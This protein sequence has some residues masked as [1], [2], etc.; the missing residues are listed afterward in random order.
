MVYIYSSILIIYSDIDEL[1][2][3]VIGIAIKHMTNILHNGL[4]SWG[5]SFV[6]VVGVCCQ[7]FGHQ[8]SNRVLVSHILPKHTVYPKML[9]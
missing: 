8:L 4:T 5:R 3:A 2:T 7:H 6:F 9:K 1:Y